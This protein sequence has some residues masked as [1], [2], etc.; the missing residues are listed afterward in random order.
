MSALVCIHLVMIN[1]ISDRSGLGHSCRSHHVISV[2]KKCFSINTFIR[3]NRSGSLYKV[4]FCHAISPTMLFM[5]LAVHSSPAS[6]DLVLEEINSEDEQDQEK[7]S[8]QP[9]ARNQAESV[10]RSG[11]ETPSL[12]APAS[13]LMQEDA[14]TQTGRW[15]PIMESIK[16]EAEDNAMATIEERLVSRSVFW[17]CWG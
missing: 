2:L 6:A 17:T 5:F 16:R 14:E 4:L 7:K 12:S 10:E 3:L 11:P 9:S 1:F 8:E 13:C 15:T